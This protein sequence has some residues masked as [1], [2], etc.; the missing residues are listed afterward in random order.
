LKRA[1]DAAF[2]RYLVKRGGKSKRVRR[3]RG[4]QIPTL[5][6]CRAE[7]NKRFP[8]TAWDQPDVTSWQG[9]RDDDGGDD[10]D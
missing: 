8:G 10:E 2:G 6:Q 1:T 7:W 4:W 5:D 9:E 3:Q